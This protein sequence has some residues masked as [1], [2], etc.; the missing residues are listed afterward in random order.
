MTY[1]DVMRHFTRIALLVVAAASCTGS[2]QGHR[3][4]AQAD[5]LTQLRSSDVP[6]VLDVRE[7]NEFVRGHVPRP[8]TSRT[9][10]LAPESAS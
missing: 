10:T 5:L 8:S 3:T 4:I 2:P 9:C 6:L 7:P 1:P